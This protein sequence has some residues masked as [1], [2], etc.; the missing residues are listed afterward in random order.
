MAGDWFPVTVNIDRRREVL[1][2]A[3]ATKRDRFQVT[4]LLVAFWSWVTEES[5]DGRAPSVTASTLS[6]AVGADEEFWLEVE[7]AGWLRFETDG[8]LVPNWDRWNSKSAKKRLQNT[9]RKRMER[10]CK[11]GGRAPVAEV[12]RSERDKSETT[13]DR[14]QRTSSPPTPPDAVGTGGGGGAAPTNGTDPEAEAAWALVLE[15][16]PRREPTV[17]NPGAYLAKLRGKFTHPR[18]AGLKWWN[19]VWAEHEARDLRRRILAHAGRTFEDEQGGQW[20]VDPGGGLVT[21]D[22]RLQPI[23]TFKRQ[24]LERIAARLEAETVEARR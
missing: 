19:E 2:I 12:S 8:L 14:G 9:L 21:P 22:G 20:K 6:I 3:A 11:P 16:L 10:E 4:G 15:Q 23:A 1:A 5:R 18:E 13:E 17:R 7:R 24:I